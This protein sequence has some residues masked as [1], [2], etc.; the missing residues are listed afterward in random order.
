MPM[1]AR[2]GSRGIGPQTLTAGQV[3]DDMGAAA[4]P[5]SVAKAEWR[6]ADRGHDADWLGESVERQGD[7]TMILELLPVLWT[8]G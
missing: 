4:L 7:R 2:S 3:S 1:A 5:G 8:A 6:L